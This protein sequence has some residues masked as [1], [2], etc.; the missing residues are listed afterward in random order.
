MAGRRSSLTGRTGGADLRANIDIAV[1]GRFSRSL[2]EAAAARPLAERAVA[3]SAC[4]PASPARRRS[5]SNGQAG[6]AVTRPPPA[7][8]TTPGELEITAR[9]CSN[10]RWILMSDR[11]GTAR[12]AVPLLIDVG[13][14]RRFSWHG[15]REVLAEGVIFVT[16]KGCNRSPI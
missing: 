11:W 1:W 7:R 8:L 6:A 4:T 2:G 16:V 10:R 5:T 3:C 14:I 9:H 15:R 13:Q 12:E